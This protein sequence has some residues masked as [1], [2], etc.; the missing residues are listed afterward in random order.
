MVALTLIQKLLIFPRRAF[1]V[2]GQVVWLTLGIWLASIFGH[3]FQKPKIQLTVP[4]L[5]DFYQVPSHRHIPLASRGERGSAVI[6]HFEVEL[7][8]K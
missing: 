6:D 5:P 4:C 2:H 3:S 1:R 8:D 7:M